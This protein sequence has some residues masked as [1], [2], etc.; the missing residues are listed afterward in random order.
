MN[1][2]SSGNG[3]GAW[4][5]SRLGDPMCLPSGCEG[6]RAEA[7]TEEAGL[8]VRRRI[9]SHRIEGLFSLRHHSRLDHIEAAFTALGKRVDIE[10]RDA[11]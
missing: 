1:S 10:V 4:V 5:R 3:R 6:E 11:A 7:L 9:R 2:H 8:K